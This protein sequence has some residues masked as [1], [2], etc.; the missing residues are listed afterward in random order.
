MNPCVMLLLLAA[1][2]V[3]AATAQGP[4]PIESELV[5][6]TPVSKFIHDASL[7]AFAGYAKDRRAHGARSFRGDPKRRDRGMLGTRD[8]PGERVAG[9]GDRGPRQRRERP[10]LFRVL[11]GQ[12]PPYDVGAATG[13]VLKPTSMTRGITTRSPS[14]E[15]SPPAFR[16]R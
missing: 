4:A 8:P 1:V 14:G 10:D 15:R 9:R 12:H 6:I 16:P 11:P 5:L 3:P 2:S 7:K 13:Q